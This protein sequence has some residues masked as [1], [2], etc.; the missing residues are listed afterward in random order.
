MNECK[1]NIRDTVTMSIDAG[2]VVLPEKSVL[3]PAHKITYLGFWLDSIDMTVTLTEAKAL[4]L[5]ISC[6]KLAEQGTTTIQS[7]AETIG[8]MVASFPGVQFE[9]LFYRNCEN[10]KYKALK[11][12]FGHYSAKTRL[13]EDCILD[14]Q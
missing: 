1:Q 3:H 12:S 10:H 13:T 2:F 4:K 6:Q 8:I 9:P 7:L 11:D 14:L 5:K